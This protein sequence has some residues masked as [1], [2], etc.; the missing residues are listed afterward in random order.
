VALY[1]T[2]PAS[3]GWRIWMATVLYKYR[4]G[5]DS[6]QPAAE[7]AAVYEELARLT[8][9]ARERRPAV[10][11]V[12]FQKFDDF[13]EW[14][15]EVSLPGLRKALADD[16]DHADAWKWNL[17]LAEWLAAGREEDQREARALVVAAARQ[18]PRPVP[19]P[20]RTRIRDLAARLRAELP[21][22][23]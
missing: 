18:A 12:E 1:P 22:S 23:F 13:V 3:F 10:L 20:V 5:P 21:P 8:R 16:P 17:E 7:Q 4:P 6:R 15:R 19:E 2:H 11:P 14:V 9:E